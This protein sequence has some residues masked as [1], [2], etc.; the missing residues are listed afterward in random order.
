MSPKPWLLIASLVVLAG[1]LGA[2][3][4]GARQQPADRTALERRFSERLG[5]VLRERLG[6]TD[7]QLVRLREV[8]QRFEG[9]RREL[10]QAEREV[11]VGMRRA[12]VDDSS[13]SNDE[14]AALMDRALRIQ[15][16]RI[17]LLEAEQ[18]ELAQFLTPVQRA[19]YFG[20]QEQL[21]RQMEEMRSRRGASD[22][23]ATPGFR[24]RPRPPGA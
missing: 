20:F 15:R 13:A 7:E 19:K 10:F 21:R 6:L 3:R 23:S 22:S 4:P 9:Q 5:A 24:R 16:Q 8:N 12:L 17:D 1:P 14:V 2:Q 18:R 11:R